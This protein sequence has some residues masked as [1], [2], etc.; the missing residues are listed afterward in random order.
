LRGEEGTREAGGQYAANAPTAANSN[1][2]NFGDIHV[3]TQATGGARVTAA[4]REAI[5]RN[6]LVS[7]ANTGLA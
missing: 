6:M 2:A 7:Q 4:L 1:T 3:Y 5:A